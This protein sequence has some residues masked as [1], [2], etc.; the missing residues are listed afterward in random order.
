MTH[1]ENLTLYLR[2]RTLNRSV[3]D[4][5]HLQSEILVH[6][7]KLH[8][9]IFYINTEIYIHHLMPHKSIHDVRETFTN[10]KYGQTA[11]IVDYV[12]TS[13]AIYHVYSLPFTFTRLENITNQFPTI[14][15]DTV[16]HLYA[17]DVVPMN[18]EFFMR[19]NR[20]FPMLKFFSLKNEMEQSWNHGEYQSDKNPSCSV[21][22]YSNL[23]SLDITHV[24]IDYVTQFLL[25]TKTCLPN[26]T[27]LKV[28][29][30]QL[31]T[32]TM[33]FTRDATRYNCSKVKRLIVEQ[34]R[35][36]SKDVYQY[37]PSL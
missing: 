15:F 2:I 28:N 14:G 12:K 20:D 31:K 34:S 35:N 10:I 1:L 18:H 29:Y 21:I 24:N 4:G 22:K 25:E 33:N 23:I 16:T 13:T 17:Y 8:T 32:V 30:N 9:F 11:C 37:F 26:L 3:V 5:T 6:M 36:F 27:E 7:P 19:I